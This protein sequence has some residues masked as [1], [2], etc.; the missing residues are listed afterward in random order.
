MRDRSRK[1]AATGSPADID[2]L[3]AFDGLMKDY[4][5]AAL[6]VFKAMEAGSLPDLASANQALDPAKKQIHAA[7]QQL[8]QLEALQQAETVQAGIDQQQID[9]QAG[10]LFAGALAAAVLLVVPLTLANMVS[11]CRPIDQA[12]RLAERIATGNLTAQPDTREVRLFRRGADGLFT[13][14]DLTGREQIRL[15]SVGCELLASDVFD[16]VESDVGQQFNLP[17]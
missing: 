14:H 8:A 2:A 15:E 1:I 3:K 10:L 11:I 7:E 6:A 4:A 17:V 9:R 12:R 5:D 16:G 13:L